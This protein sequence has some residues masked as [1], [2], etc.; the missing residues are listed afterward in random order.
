MVRTKEWY[1][2]LRNPTEWAARMAMLTIANAFDH[3]Q[4]GRATHLLDLRDNRPFKSFTCPFGNPQAAPAMLKGKDW[5]TYRGSHHTDHS[6]REE[7]FDG[8]AAPDRARGDHMLDYSYIA[9]AADRENAELMNGVSIS[10]EE[11]FRD[12]GN[13]KDWRRRKPV[14]FAAM[15]SR[16]TAARRPHEEEK[17]ISKAL[18]RREWLRDYH[19]PGDPH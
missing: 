12:I 9:G 17:K 19:H 4:A 3:P 14:R 8:H 13:P 15:V 7:F 11:V 18:S 5:T 1:Q 2:V 6:I 16:F 10:E